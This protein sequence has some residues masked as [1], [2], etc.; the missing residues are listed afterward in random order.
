MPGIAG[1]IGKRWSSGDKSSIELMINRMLH[2][3]FY[4]SGTYSNDTLG[5]QV[6]WVC[7]KDSFSDCLPVWNETRDVCLVFSGEIF[8]EETDF[9]Q[10]RASGHQFSP[11]TASYLVHLYEENGLK[12]L[13]ALNGWFSGV[14]VDLR[15]SKIVLFN[16][17]YGMGRIYYHQGADALYFASEAKSLLK[18]LPESRR[19]DPASLGEFFSCG[20]PL[21]NRTLFSGISL[22][23]GAA[24]WTSSPN[25][26]MRK[27]AYFSQEFWENQPALGAV[28]YY[29]RLKE[30][31]SRVLPRYLRGD[32]LTGLSLTGGVDSR[33]IMAFGGCIP[34][35]L[36]CYTFAGKYRDNV[37]VRIARRVAEICGRP[38]QVVRLDGGF[39]SEFPT[40]AEKAVYLTDG[41]LDV[42][43]AADLYMNIKAREIA[44]VR[45][46][47]NYGGEILRSI[48][49]FKPALLH[50]GLFAPEFARH[51]DTA[52]ETYA[53]ERRGNRL[54]FIAFKQVP[55]HHYCRL[56]LE[57][58]Q[59]TIRSPYLDNEFVQLVYRAPAEVA[60]GNELSLRLI[61]DGNPALSRIGTDRGILHRPIPVVTR[62]R[63]IL[64][65][66]TFKAEYA[67]DYGMPQW[68]A[69]L[70]HCVAPLHLER[71]F[72]GRH[73]ISH[74]RVLY[75][76]HASKYLQDTLLDSRARS[77]PY[78][79]RKYLEKIV[80]DHVRGHGNYTQELHRVLALE[81]LQRQLIEQSLAVS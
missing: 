53:K 25:E 2:E 26:G 36:H 47:G 34:K 7:H 52:S 11:N 33:L 55:W 51:V 32:G 46:T 49:A 59:L 13:E 70:D 23:P 19:F 76:D 17:R 37:D 3:P 77:R 9:I 63:R 21:Q 67:Y 72:L 66:F 20:C 43:G 65:E 35:N 16:D 15:L 75:R 38:H 61:A 27:E 80:E 44:R 54:S 79:R 69:R 57:Q 73:K 5:L 30:T 28:E 81:I 6:G 10:L 8:S 58:S 71:M 68:L 39:L 74:F 40:L 22:L 18:I 29:Q 31:F 42:T 4:T 14:L 45:L 60:T 48:V 78:L 56:G 50:S 41:A 24:M 64:Q 1:I 62:A 12:F